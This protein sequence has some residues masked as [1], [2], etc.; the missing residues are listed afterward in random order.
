M[1]TSRLVLPSSVAS[2]GQDRKYEITRPELG[3]A[4]RV[5]MDI[6][7]AGEVAEEFHGVALVVTSSG[8]S[9]STSTRSMFA[10]A[11]FPRTS[12]PRFAHQDYSAE[13]I[14]SASGNT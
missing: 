7:P 13:G 2:F 6:V 14:V 5:E 12:K 9:K 4:G 11:C 1:K 8:L 3:M 10:N